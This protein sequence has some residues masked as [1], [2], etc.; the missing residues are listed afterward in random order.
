MVS[1]PL[2]PRFGVSGAIPLP[3]GFFL[4][5]SPG[6]AVFEARSA[7]FHPTK[8]YRLT[9]PAKIQLQQTRF[10]FGPSASQE[11]IANRRGLSKSHPRM[12][13]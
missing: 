9:L 4:P 12:P 11:A 13:L 7:A 6:L 2:K 3:D 8:I 10:S 1:G 5:V